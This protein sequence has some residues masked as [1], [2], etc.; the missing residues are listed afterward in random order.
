M[1]RQA[2]PQTSQRT[3][4]Q[5]CRP[6]VEM[7]PDHVRAQRCADT[8]GGAGH[9]K[10]VASAMSPDRH[11]DGPGQGQANR[12]DESRGAATPEPGLDTQARWLSGM[13]GDSGCCPRHTS[14]HRCRR[15]RPGSGPRG[16]RPD[17]TPDGLRR[18]GAPGAQPIRT[19][20]TPRW[21]VT[22]AKGGVAET[23]APIEP[24]L[25]VASFTRLRLP[26]A[27]LNRLPVLGTVQCSTLPRSSRLTHR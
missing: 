20:D 8:D 1:N 21:H 22:P 12:D 24:S 10:V 13:A 16:T 14:P 11:V 26:S 17:G 19:T 23:T 3:S 6:V 15:V 4:C 27:S 2:G 7:T 5:V 18:P 25:D 9:L